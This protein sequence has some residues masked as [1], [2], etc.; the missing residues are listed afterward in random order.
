MKVAKELLCGAMVLAMAASAAA[1]AGATTLR[2][3]GLDELVATNRAV[4]VG[5]VVDARSYWNEDHTF[6]LTDVR[7]AMHDV[8]KGDVGREELTITLMGG[9][10]GEMTALIVG[11]ARLVPGNSYLLFLDEEKLPGI[12]R[13][14][15]VREHSQGAFDIKIGRGGLRA[16]S[17]ANGHPLVPDRQGYTEAPGGPEGMHLNTMMQSVRQI[18]A[19]ERARKEVQ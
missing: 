12:G 15:T 7:I 18:V 14:L 11:G 10:V 1:P 9:E 3:L 2:R 17:Q 13:A 19:R 4:V 16:V 5:E 8:L 6:I